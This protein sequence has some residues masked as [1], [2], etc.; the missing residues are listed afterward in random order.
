M[1]TLGEKSTDDAPLS[2]EE[3]P[4]GLRDRRLNHHLVPDRPIPLAEAPTH[5]E[6]DETP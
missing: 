1:T 2:A 6:P 5:V 4:R 3:A